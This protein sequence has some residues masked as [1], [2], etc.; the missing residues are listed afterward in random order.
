[1]WVFNHLLRKLEQGY[2][3]FLNTKFIQDKRS[4]VQMTHPHMLDSIQVF[5]GEKSQN[6][7]ENKNR[8]GGKERKEEEIKVAHSWL[9]LCGVKTCCRQ[10]LLRT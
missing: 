1:M 9:E 2:I 6:R 4:G 3:F 5:F 8:E 10:A 7:K